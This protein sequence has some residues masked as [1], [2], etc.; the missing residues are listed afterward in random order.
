LKKA[1]LFFA[2]ALFI[3]LPAA[4]F[5]QISYNPVSMGLGGGGT[6][7]ITDYEALFTNP[8]N[9]QLREKNY[10]LQITLGESG[11]YFDT[12]LRVRDGRDRI[13][14]FSETLQSPKPGAYTFSGDE[15]QLLLD[16][17][18]NNSRDFRQ[19]Q[20]SSV[21]NWLGIK[22]FGEEKSY[23]FAVRTRQ[24]SRY[25]VG[26]GFYDS[27]PVDAGDFE[28]INRSLTH[29]YQTL[30]EVSFGYSESFTFL[31]GL[32]PR[33]SKFIIGLAPKVVVA[34]PGYSTQFTNDF[35]REN[36]TSPWE[37]N[38]SYEFESSGIFSNYA[39]RFSAGG[40]PFEELGMISSLN[41][42]LTPTGVGAAIDLGVT[43][44]FTFGD[45]LSLIRRGEEPTEKSLRLSFSITDLGLI[46]TFENPLRAEGEIE[47][48]QDPEPGV[49]S[50][51]Y[52][53]GAL[54]QDFS[55][56]GTGVNDTHPLQNLRSTDRDPY[57]TLLPTSIQTGVLF[58]INRI[59][60]MGDFRLGLTDNAFHSTKFT[61]YIGTEVRLLPF[62]PL[63]A[64]TRLAT[65]LPGYYS[66][67]AG[68]ETTYFDINAAVQFRSTSAGPT[69]EPVA[70][71]AV[72]VK[73]YIP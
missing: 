52:Y 51:N 26:R 15:R 14:L 20:T 33:T 73:F 56:L 11:A 3:L 55:F 28:L 5:S 47:Q 64:G 39:E 57:Q 62:L 72:A 6:S 8:A 60:M 54:L 22:W 48:S 70:A 36:A 21:I 23:A 24:S 42:L 4:T 32:F 27:Q 69:L 7:Y 29:R 1:A 59:K 61:S 9:L 35:T 31:S 45:D 67:G 25:S 58:Q 2:T 12:P 13:E 65:D 66:F 40:D 44:L 71:S 10:D 53:A 17:Y 50:E 38:S 41:D 63:R 18:Y 30:H 49:V 37:R 16:R 68:I 19:M 34:G 46:H 43:Y